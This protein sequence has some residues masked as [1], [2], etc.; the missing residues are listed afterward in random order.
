MQIFRHHPPFNAQHPCVLTIGNFD[1]VHRGHQ[2]VI[3]HLSR[4]GKAKG[5][6]VA[7]LTF[8]PHPREYFEKQGRGNAPHRIQ[9]LRDKAC[10]LEAAGVDQLL[11]AHFNKRLATLPAEKFIESYLVETLQIK[12]LYVGD[13]FQFGAG[14]LGNFE[15]LKAKGLVHGYSVER[16]PTLEIDGERVSSSLARQALA[17]SNFSR[18]AQLLGRPYSISG[19][20]IHGRKLGRTLGFPT[21]NMLV[22][23]ASTSGTKPLLHGIYAVRIHHLS[24]KSF[25]GVASLGTRPAVEKNGRYLLETHVF[26]FK[27]DAYGQTVSVEFVAKL[28]DEANY[29]SL[30]ALTTQINLDAKQAKQILLR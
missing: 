7:V 21:L 14:R 8:D 12:H 30:E 3:E 20:V 25:S 13:D 17:D 29:D 23:G 18:A 2:A 5:L 10:A 28:R 15:M 26:G 24:G 9:S 1:G 16:M 22:P 27:G 19:K 4:I 11:V 6:P